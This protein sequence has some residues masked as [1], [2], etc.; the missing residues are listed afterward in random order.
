[1]KVQLQW[2]ARHLE[3]AA[4]P[5]ACQIFTNRPESRSRLQS[6]RSCAQIQ[7]RHSTRM[8]VS[9]SAN[10]QVPHHG[11]ALPGT[12]SEC[13]QAGQEAHCGDWLTESMLTLHR[14]TDNKPNFSNASMFLSGGFLMTIWRTL[15]GG[16]QTPRSAT[17]AC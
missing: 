8:T 7:L 1:M 6:S 14:G 2:I 9:H 17:V 16:D 3:T 5:S 11:K 13:M 12:N 4:H 10:A 15:G